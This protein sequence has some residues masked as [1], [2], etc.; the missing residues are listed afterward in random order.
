[1]SIVASRMTEHTRAL[2]IEL[3][4]ASSPDLRRSFLAVNVERRAAICW[5]SV[6]G[7]AHKR[8]RDFFQ[9]LNTALLH[10]SLQLDA[11]EF[12][13]ALHPRLAEGA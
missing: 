13:H 5:C 1:M 9:I 8:W 6:S 3:L 12:H 11:E 7:A 4:V 2:A 10:R